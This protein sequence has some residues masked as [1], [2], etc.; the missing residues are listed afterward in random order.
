MDESGLFYQMGPRKSY[1][2]LNED[3]R[4][5]RGTELQRQKA[6]ITIVPCVD[7]DG[8]HSVPVNYVGHATE[9]RCFRNNRSDEYRAHSSSQENASMDSTQFNKWIHWW[10][11]ELRRENFD[12]ILLVMVMK[13]FVDKQ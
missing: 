4:H 10:Y 13:V 11:T 9:P 5:A 12:D 1:L 3:P 2:S 8:S 6:R 7:A